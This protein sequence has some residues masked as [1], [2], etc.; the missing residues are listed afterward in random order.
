MY[1]LAQCGIGSRIPGFRI[2]SEARCDMCDA[3]ITHAHTS[4]MSHSVA[5][6][7][8]YTRCYMH[9]KLLQA[10]MM[11]RVPYDT[12]VLFAIHAL[13]WAMFGLQLYWGGVMVCKAVLKFVLGKDV[14]TPKALKSPGSK[15]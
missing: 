4:H 10:P 12:P 8:N 11:A 9:Y 3:Y 7:F 6:V 15:R 5:A 1:R 13:M 14:T 2:A